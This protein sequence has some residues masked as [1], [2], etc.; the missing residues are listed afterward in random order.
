MADCASCGEPICVRTV[1]ERVCE[2]CPNR[3]EPA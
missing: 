2:G 1:V 3:K